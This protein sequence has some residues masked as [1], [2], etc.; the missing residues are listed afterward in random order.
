MLARSF[1]NSYNCETRISLWTPCA[2]WGGG[3]P[4]PWISVCVERTHYIGTQ[5][6]RPLSVAVGRTQSLFVAF[7]SLLFTSVHF[8]AFIC[9]HSRLFALILICLHSFAFVHFQSHSFAFGRFHSLSITF[10]RF[11]S[12]SITFIRFC[13]LSFTLAHF[14]LF[15]F[16]LKLYWLLRLTYASSDL[17]ISTSTCCPTPFIVKTS[18]SC[19]SLFVV[20]RMIHL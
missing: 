4:I 17:V 10:I 14:K 13:S 3:C 1:V 6:F 12:L 11:R 15:L 7:H 20:L 5:H 2:A 9:F 18:A 19:D 8:F 16:H